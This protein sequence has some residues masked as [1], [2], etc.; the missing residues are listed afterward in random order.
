MLFNKNGE[1]PC[2]KDL[3]GNPNTVAASVCFIPNICFVG[4]E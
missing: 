4:V 1:M 3:P 2:I